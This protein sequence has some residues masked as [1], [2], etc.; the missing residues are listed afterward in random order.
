MTR[1]QK[2]ALVVEACQQLILRYEDKYDTPITGEY[3]IDKD[4]EKLFRVCIGN[5]SWTARDIEI[6]EIYGLLKGLL[7]QVLD[8]KVI[9]T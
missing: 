2:L 1:K 5:R 7:E 4:V 8:Q 3:G 9:S 6:N